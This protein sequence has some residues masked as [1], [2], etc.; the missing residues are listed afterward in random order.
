MADV[1]E[2]PQMF[3]SELFAAHEVD[4]LIILCLIMLTFR[5]S[6]CAGPA[7][8]AGGQHSTHRS[9]RER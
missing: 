2:D 8:W 7:N 5:W 4:T 3:L 6:C 1:D 9:V